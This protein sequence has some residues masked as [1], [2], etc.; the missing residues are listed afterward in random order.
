MKEVKLYQLEVTNYR[1]IEHEV[2]MFGGKNA[3]IVGENRIGK[4]NT[5]EAIYF[6]LT[7]YL[8]DGSSDLTQLKPLADTKRVVS[9]K[10]IFDV[11]GKE[12]TLEKHYEEEWQRTRGTND[13]VLKG[14]TETYFFNGIKQSKSTDY[15]ELLEEHFGIRNDKKGEVDVIQMLCNPLYLGNLGESKDWTDLRAFI[16]K[17]IGDVTDDE[18]FKA[19]PTTALI[20]Q[21]LERAL[22][23]TDQVKRLYENDIKGLNTALNAHNANITLLERTEKPTDEDIAKAQEGIEEI[24]T[25]IG[26]AQSKI[27]TNKATEL[28]EKDVF[29]LKKKVLELNTQE[30][31]EYQKAH[32]SNSGASDKV[33]ELNKQLEIALDKATEIKFKISDAKGDKRIAEVHIETCTAHRDEYAKRFTELRDK[34]RD[35]DNHIQ[36][37]CPTCNRPLDE[38][39]VEEAR[40]K[41]LASLDEEIDE[42]TKEGK[43]NTEELNGYKI[44]L[45]EAN[46]KVAIFEQQLDEANKEIDEI[47]N[48]IASAKLEVATN[49]VEGDEYT[50]SDKLKELRKLL[51]LREKDLEE[52]KQK[53]SEADST[54]AKAIDELKIKLAKY[55]KVIDDYTYFKRQMGVLDH[56]L[57]EKDKCCKAIADLEQKKEC[58]QL[59]NYTKLRLLDKHVAKVFGDIKF[60]LIRENINGGFDPVCKPYIFDIEKNA[61]TD[62]IWKSGSKS[63]KIVTGIAIVEHIKSHLGLNDLPYLFDEGGEISTD[64]LYHKFKTNAQ[65][66]CVKVEDNINKPVVVNF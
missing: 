7:N 53:D 38:A 13:L 64:T 40:K 57:E 58:L 18:V 31:A 50:E 24:N 26:E 23:K 4:T 44:K 42:V 32:S 11:D 2:F 48:Q 66:I 45:E 43:A 17:L 39:V 60:Q 65:I 9:V 22:G 19:E 15:Y 46:D 25:M 35:V 52:A 49:K 37:V 8:L 6:L 28:L 54:Y 36:T 63:E 3:K 61:S 1:N 5:L 56:V 30:Y 47:R 51:A 34:A 20:K 27:G 29:D 16:I 41:Y 12:I 59:F 33:D 62:T 14:H 21:D 10:G 55:Q